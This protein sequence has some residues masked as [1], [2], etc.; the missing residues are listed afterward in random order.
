VAAIRYAIGALL[1]TLGRKLFWLFVAATGFALGLALATRLFGHRP[2]WVALL[3][4]LAL[5]AIGALLALFVQRLAIRAAGFFAGAFLANS[6]AGALKLGHSPWFWVAVAAGGILGAV[7]TSTVFDWALV[8]L[9]S[10]AGAS[11][12][13][14]GLRLPQGASFAVWLALVLLGVIIQFGLMR[15][16]KK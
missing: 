5:G 4:A 8:G 1:L 7:L 15:K 3:I 6:L 11:L 2:E 13:V 10:L 14:E 16:K 12:I 9:S